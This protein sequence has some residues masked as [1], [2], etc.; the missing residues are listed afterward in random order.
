MEMVYYPID[1]VERTKELLQ[2]TYEEI[3][4]TSQLEVSFLINCLLGLVVMVAESKKGKG[5][6]KDKE[7]LRNIRKINIKYKESLAE[8]E[9]QWFLKKMRNA[10][11]H[12]NIDPINENG[13]WT[14]AKMWNETKD[15]IRD[16]EISLTNTELKE[17]ALNIANDYLNQRQQ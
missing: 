16:F 9:Y 4:K 7:F 17:L 15:G 3:K 13:K 14:G 2:N 10:I 1:I 6:V 11:A 12:Q 8:K 5:L